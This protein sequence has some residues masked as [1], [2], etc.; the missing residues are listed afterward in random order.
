MDR[1]EQTKMK[2][3]SC[4]QETNVVVAKEEHIYAEL[5]L[6]LPTFWRF[7]PPA[8][9]RLITAM[10]GAICIG[11]VWLALVWLNRGVWFMSAVAGLL[12]LF[13]LYIFVACV[14]SLGKHRLKESYKC[15]ACGLEWS[16]SKER[17]QQ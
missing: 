14:R 3:P 15:N 5:F 13:S 17:G 12:A 10:I 4:S 6:G 8:T 2:C 11:L 1:D 7:M 16:W 9:A